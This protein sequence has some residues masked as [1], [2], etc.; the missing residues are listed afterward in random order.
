M[1]LTIL[2][3][4]LRRKKAMN[5][6]LFVLITLA[7]TLVSSSSNLMYSSSTAVNSFIEQS[8]VADFN[9]S[10]PNTTEYN[11]DIDAWA[12][13]D[14]NISSYQSELQMGVLSKQIGLPEGRKSISGNIGLTLATV[15]DKVNLVFG[16][17]DESFS[18]QQG[19]IALPVSIKNATGLKLGDSI[20]VDLQGVSK[21]F[22]VQ[23]FFKDAFMGSELLGLKRLMIS[24]ADFSDLQEVL[25]GES[26]TR[27]WSFTAVPG[28]DAG[29]L[30][31]AFSNKDLPL[32]NEIEKALVKTSYLTDKIISAM[33]FAISVFLIFIAFLTLR[34]TIVSTLQDDYKEIGVM[35]AIGFRNRAIRR[36]YLTKYTALALSGGVVGFCI[37]LP[38]TRLMSRKISQY[39]IV[40]GT[41][42]GIVVSVIS[43]LMIVGITLWFCSLSM[44][45]INKASAIDAIRQ[46]HTGERFK[47]SRKIHLHKSKFMPAAL[48]LALS[49]LL[50]RMKSYS[51]LI[52]TFILSTAIIL[53]PINL[54][55]TI[56]TPK[57]IGYFGVSVADFYTKS[58]TA[59][60]PVND[61]QSD[62]AQLAREFANKGFPVTLAVDYVVN[63]KYIS[64]DGLENRW[65][66]GAKSEPAADISYLEGIAP[67]LANEI[68]ITSM[69]SEN[70]RKNLGD[71][72]VLE[73]DG[74]RYTFLI[75]GIFQTITNEGYMVRLAEEFT[76][77]STAAHQY[78]GK[79]QVPD[80]QKALVIRDLQQEFSQLDIKSA[81]AL[82]AE[83]TGG[84]MGQLKNI[85]LI[86]T[87]IVCLITFFITS[88]FVRLLITRE[89]QGIALMKSLGL[90]NRFI[91]VWQV[92]RIMVLL[93]ASILVG[94]LLTNTLGEKLIGIIFRMF[95]LTEI[96]FN[97]VFLQVYL[98]YPLLILAVVT[99]AVYS[100][101]G[102]IRKIQVWN[103]NQE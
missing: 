68:A 96:S 103:I 49:D 87:L 64:D 36:L 76:P 69:M 57:F 13:S 99:L 50:N 86:V 18:L 31:A 65:I 10:L 89:V 12:R 27:Q 11:H 17:D 59:D 75:T 66:S 39:I 51:A 44:R 70:Y 62:L 43:T 8:K 38:L 71:S 63:T 81:T 16:S 34:F 28:T 7:A 60:K 35:K 22:K 29:V 97:I 77:V 72:I 4:D 37:S 25:P 56:V 61:L 46:G 53:F 2:K 1:F 3:K 54:T 80:D 101:C 41:G 40:P 74:S 19:E 32:N 98:I 93:V 47:V 95:G 100:S 6:V 90:T 33:L 24:G 45:K 52:V 88:L 67:K 79:L 20:T 73:I 9:I 30:S 78:S 83:T 55:N 14:K 15:P 102:G 42:S 85:N 48:F 92:F 91:R 94:V 82:L 84:F 21:T 26:F 58:E 23:T 5:I